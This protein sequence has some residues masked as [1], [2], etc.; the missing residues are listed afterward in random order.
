MGTA[1]L[2]EIVEEAAY[3]GFYRGL[4]FINPE[5]SDKKIRL[6]FVDTIE[7]GNLPIESMVKKSTRDVVLLGFMAAFDGMDFSIRKIVNTFCEIMDLDLTEEQKAALH[8]QANRLQ[9]WK[10]KF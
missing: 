2:I 5:F 9:T 7:R 3:K 6:L 10:N 8:M 4:I 1:N